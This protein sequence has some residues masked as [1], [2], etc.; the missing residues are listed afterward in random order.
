MAIENVVDDILTHHGVKGMHWGVKR[1]MTVPVEG[2]KSDDA[3]KAHDVSQK[4][5]TGGTHS[6]SNAELQHLVNRMNLE[7]QY[8]R[9]SGSHEQT[10]GKRFANSLLKDSKDVA[11]QT[12][13]TAAAGILAKK[14]AVALAKTALG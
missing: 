11:R 7:Q 5:K 1:K 6:V 9:L 14:L 10:K 3:S 2:H 8:S 4:I 12:V 13:K